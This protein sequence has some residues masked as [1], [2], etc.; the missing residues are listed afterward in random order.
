MKLILLSR[1]SRSL[2]RN[3]IVFFWLSQELGWVLSMAIGNP[4]KEYLA[5]APN[6]TRFFIDSHDVA[7]KMDRRLT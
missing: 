6:G 7:V 2:N 1:Q 3:C 5:S 4:T